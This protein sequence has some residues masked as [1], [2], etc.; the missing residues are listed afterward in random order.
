MPVPE[1]DPDY[2]K[3][4][5][6]LVVERNCYKD[7]YVNILA[8]SDLYSS[9]MEG[10]WS[11][12]C[13][14]MK[15]L[16]QQYDEGAREIDEIMRERPECSESDRVTAIDDLIWMSYDVL[17]PGYGESLSGLNYIRGIPSTM[18][19]AYLPYSSAFHLFIED[20]MFGLQAREE[21]KMYPNEEI[22]KTHIKTQC[23]AFVS[24][25]TNIMNTAV[26]NGKELLNNAIENSK[27]REW[28]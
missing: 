4:Y 15:L 16:A 21:I 22:I 28:F 18:F 2:E 26:V 19:F 11:N 27:T 10:N 24:I 9:Y 12:Y 8:T 1:N 20:K 17:F 3:I 5:N 7:V 14:A 23:D 13:E 25:V 6:F